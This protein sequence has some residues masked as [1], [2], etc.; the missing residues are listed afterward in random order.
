MS[1]NNVRTLVDEAPEVSAPAPLYAPHEVIARLSP[2]VILDRIV[3]AGAPPSIKIALNEGA[4]RLRFLFGPRASYRFL[5]P[6][7]YPAL[8]HFTPI[9]KLKFMI[10]LFS[11]FV[12]F[13]WRFDFCAVFSLG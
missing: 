5:D 13:L 1:S 7:L 2:F 10:R 4:R 11:V 9:R 3:V 12:A 8:D 6:V